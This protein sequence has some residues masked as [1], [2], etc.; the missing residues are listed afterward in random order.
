MADDYDEET[1]LRPQVLHVN[2]DPQLLLLLREIHYLSQ[3]PFYVA[4][5]SA[6]RWVVMNDAATGQPRSAGG[7]VI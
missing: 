5:P 6:A 3:A 4:V 1:E 2:L 7:A